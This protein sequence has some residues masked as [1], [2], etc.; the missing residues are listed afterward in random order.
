MVRK[1]G[2]QKEFFFFFFFPLQIT[3]EDSYYFHY[4]MKEETYMKRLFPFVRG[5]YMIITP[6]VC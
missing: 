1:A 4:W 3:P 6:T 5:T 2:M